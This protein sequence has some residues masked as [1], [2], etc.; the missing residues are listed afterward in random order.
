MVLGKL[1]EIHSDNIGQ[2]KAGLSEQAEGRPKVGVEAIRLRQVVADRNGNDLLAH[3][4]VACRENPPPDDIEHA[5]FP[6]PRR[7]QF[8]VELQQDF[9]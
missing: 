6:A 4:P 3:A 5:L 7:Q 2:R 1:P 8:A 9:I